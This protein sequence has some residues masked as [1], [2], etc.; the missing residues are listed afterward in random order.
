MA[1]DTAAE[2]RANLLASRARWGKAHRPADKPPNTGGTGDY[3][4]DSIQQWLISIN[5]VDEKVEPVQKSAAEPLRRNASAEDDLVLGVEASI[6]GNPGARTV[7]EFLR[8]SLSSSTLPRWNSLTSAFSTQSSPLSVMDVLNL[9]SDDPEEVLF[10][11]GFGVEEPDITGRIPARFI[12]NQSQARGINLQVFLD[13]QKN[14]MDIENPDVRNRFRQLEVLHQ[15]TTA[16]NSLVGGGAGGGPSSSQAALANMSPEAR[17][18]RK[19]MGMLLRRASKKT[20]TQARASQERPLSPVA[21]SPADPTADPEQPAPP[22]T[23]VATHL[24]EKRGVL[25]R[26][27]TSLVENG[28][29][30]PLVEEQGP[31]QEP[32][33]VQPQT[34]VS[35]LG[36]QESPARLRGI[37]EPRSLVPTPP[38]RKRSPGEPMESF[39]LEEIQ[40]F[41]EG[42]VS[43][44]VTG[45]ADCIGESERG[46]LSRGESSVVRTNSCQSDSSGFLEE[47]FIPVASQA[48]SPGP[49]LMKALNAMSSSTES[50]GTLRGSQEPSPTSPTFPDPLFS[51]LPPAPH[52]DAP[53]SDPAESTAAPAGEERPATPPD[54]PPEVLPA[55]SS[56][57]P[58]G[59]EYDAASAEVREDASAMGADQSCQNLECV[60]CVNTDSRRS[61]YTAEDQSCPFLESCQN[62]ECVGCVNTDS[63]RSSYAAEDQSCPLLESCPKLECVGC[64]NT[65]SRQSS[66]TAEDQSCPLLESCQNLECVGCV[67]TDSRRSSSAAEDQSCPFLESCQNLECVGCVN[68]DSRRSSSAAEDVTCDGAS[69]T[70]ESPEGGE[71]PSSELD[72]EPRPHVRERAISVVLEPTLNEEGVSNVRDEGSTGEVSARDGVVSLIVSVSAIKEREVSEC[73]EAEEEE[74]EG[75]ERVVSQQ[76]VTEHVQCEP[77]VSETADS[78]SKASESAACTVN[79]NASKSVVSKCE[80]VSEHTVREDAP[81]QGAQ[82]STTETSQLVDSHELSNGSSVDGDSA[83]M[84]GTSVDGDSVPMEPS[85]TDGRPRLPGRSVSVQM[86]SSLVPASQTALRKGVAQ[87]TLSDVA[88]RRD[89]FSRRAW[90]EAEMPPPAPQSLAEEIPELASTGPFWRSRDS[91]QGFGKFQTRSVSLDTGLSWEEDDGRLDG[92]LMAGRAARRCQCQC[93]CCTQHGPHT[94]LSQPASALPYSLDELEGMVRGVKRFRDVLTDVEE[95]LGHEQA[96]VYEDLSVT[97]REEVRDVLELRAAVK[98]EARELELQLADLVQHYDGSVKM[99]ISRLLDEQS[100]LC[101]QLKIQPS[102]RPRPYPASSRS[103]AI[104]CS[105][106][107]VTDTIDPQPPPHDLS[108]ST[109]QAEEF[110]PPV[111]Q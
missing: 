44:S 67:N 86:R 57:D 30:A 55:G 95:R 50:Q 73:R 89:A 107:P 60:G 16:F 105:L 75:V 40:S 80:N 47:P 111:H 11:L 21:D 19:R 5:R 8:S 20:L 4:Q 76:A 91:S 96:S 58:T 33:E 74:E 94:D 92:V 108:R 38:L 32:S 85:R 84:E 71:Q 27:R 36:L 83:L 52:P 70:A 35:P 49:E 61:S 9:W 109:K 100:H 22:P 3:K 72:N 101:S 106:L 17:E 54:A 99:K 56:V 66:H 87:D 34:V 10:D 25:K 69:V 62:L 31:L 103:V 78:Q 42:S 2:K 88:Q 6:Y 82:M 12:N 59:G 53:T 81:N 7:K 18:K 13:A 63:R 46:F 102:D 37:R 51:S 98:Q 39:E 97:D 64:V 45:M 43:G 65:D 68:T 41:D 104:Q 79:G 23:P 28:S 110:D 29:L 77:V 48:P 24:A 14:R 15:V 1:A 26:S 93:L 90:S